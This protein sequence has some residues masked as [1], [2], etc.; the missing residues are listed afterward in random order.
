M[1]ISGVGIVLQ[2]AIDFILIPKLGVMAVAVSNCFV[3]FLMAL[4]LFIVFYKRYYK[5]GTD[6]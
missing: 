1:I 2:I 5:I 4:A 6:T 3:F